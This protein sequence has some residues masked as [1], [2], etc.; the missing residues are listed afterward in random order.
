MNIRRK[1]VKSS[2]LNVIAVVVFAI[3]CSLKPSAANASEFTP[4]GC[5]EENAVQILGSGGPI[6]D[7][8]RASAAYL[9]WVDGSS[10]LLIDAGGGTFLRFGEVGAS[11]EELDH[12]GITHFHTDHAGDLP[13]L[14]KG[15]YFSSRRRALSIS[16]PT[17][18]GPFP[19]L[20][21]F[22]NRLFSPSLGA[23]AYLSDVLIDG[24]D[25]FQL[26]PSEVSHVQSNRE[27][28]YQDPK[29]RVE[30][31]SVAHGPVPALAYVVLMENSKIVFSGDQ[32]GANAFFWKAAEGAELLIMDHAI[33]Q[34]ASRIASNLHA[35]PSEIGEAAARANIKHLVL[36]HLM[37]RSLTK[38]NQTKEL[39]STRFKGKL[40]V[41]TD[42]QCLAW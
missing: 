25:L 34:D 27:V 31:I 35:R 32:S 12:I 24:G 39:I 19:S 37:N 38:L 21:Q 3:T 36:S 4:T 5:A 20:E 41:G 1:R 18:Q 30:A 9:L 42:L 2:T 10:K 28:V 7:D 16:G 6:P 23:Y 13:E 26:Q 22:L 29:I 40:S 17:G 11:I 33:P 14:V 8:D 15:G